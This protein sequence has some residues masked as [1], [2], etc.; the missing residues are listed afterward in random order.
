MSPAQL[1]EELNEL[2]AIRIKYPGLCALNFE[3]LLDIVLE[4]LVGDNCA[5]KGVFGIIDGFGVAVEE[6]GRKTLHAHILVYV[7]EWNKIL[8]DL[9]SR[10]P[11]TRRE[12]EAKVK[13]FVDDV[14]STQLSPN[15]FNRN[16]NGTVV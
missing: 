3:F 14:M 6:Q 16:S 15:G 11:R 4:Y 13:A 2:G 9:N 10:S 8:E 12:A 7:K 5:K 1:E